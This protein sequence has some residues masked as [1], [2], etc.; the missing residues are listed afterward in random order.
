MD[1][2]WCAASSGASSFMPQDSPA[3]AR[4]VRLRSS[5]IHVPSPEVVAR[6]PCIAGLR[7]CRR[8]VGVEEMQVMPECQSFRQWDRGIGSSPPSGQVV[9]GIA[10]W[11]VADSAPAQP[12]CEVPAAVRTSSTVPC[13]KS[14]EHNNSLK[15]TRLAA[16]MSMV[17]CPPPSYRMKMPSPSRRAA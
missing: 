10:R 1:E 4:S 13:P 14:C 11:Q 6:L 17:S 15:P 9:A 16:E 12:G 8:K 2:E 5:F 7:R 3:M